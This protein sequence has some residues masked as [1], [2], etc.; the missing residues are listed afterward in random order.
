MSLLE[1]TIIVFLS[2]HGTH[3]GDYGL[4]QKQTFYEPVVKVPFILCYP[5]KFASGIAIETPV[6]TRWLLPSLLELLG[7]DVLEDCKSESLADTLI[8]GVEPIE[9][10]VFSEFTLGTFGIREDNKLVMVIN[11][12]WKFSTCISEKISD[13]CL[14]N[15]REDP[16]ELKNLFSDES[17]KKLVEGLLSLII[18][19]LR[20]L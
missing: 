8:F 13:C 9:K 2:D 1:N 7:I 16:Y 19:H 18:K 5:S 17:Y 3:I 20:L 12:N 4:L 11:H 15:M 6:E 10:P 14:Y